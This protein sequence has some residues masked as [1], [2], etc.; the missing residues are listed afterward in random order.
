VNRTAAK[1]AEVAKEV[2]RRW[3]EAQVTVG[4]PPGQVDL[5]L[6]ATSLGLKPDDPLP[7]DRKHFVLKQAGAVYDMIY[8]PAETPFLA[9]ARGAGLRVANGMGMLLYQG[10]RALEIWAQRPAP[11]PVMKAALTASLYG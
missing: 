5:V 8:R 1:A 10:A 3:P 11:I 2:H 6:N 7:F 9:E 4:Y